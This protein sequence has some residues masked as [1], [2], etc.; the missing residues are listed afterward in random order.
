[1]SCKL[2]G[3][4][5][6]SL[7]LM[8]RRLSKRSRWNCAFPHRK[9]PADKAQKASVTT[10]VASK[11][12][13]KSFFSSAV[14]A[15]TTLSQDRAGRC[16][17]RQPERSAPAV[18]HLQGCFPPHQV[19]FLLGRDVQPLRHPTSRW[20][21]CSRAHPAGARSG[22]ANQRGSSSLDRCYSAKRDVCY[23]CQTLGC[24]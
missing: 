17:P 12:P 18:R 7:V 15:P 5:Y 10:F 19:Q 1:M 9:P 22:R 21:F 14:M 16:P 23:R 3:S 24:D 2:V 13:G 6:I 4:T 11:N 20:G 8:E